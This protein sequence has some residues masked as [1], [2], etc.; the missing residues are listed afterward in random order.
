[1]DDCSLAVIQDERFKYVHFAALPP[2]L[3]D[4]EKDPNQFHNVADDPAY[5][6]TALEYAQAMLS[7]RLSHADKRLTGFSASPNGLIERR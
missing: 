3:F 4:L 2:L 6:Q 7:W 5:A 1:M